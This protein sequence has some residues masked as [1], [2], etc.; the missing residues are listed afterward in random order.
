[1]ASNTFVLNLLVFFCNYSI[2]ISQKGSNFSIM[3]ILPNLL[4]NDKVMIWKMW[5][6]ASL[7][8]IRLFTLGTTIAQT[9]VMHYCD[10]E[11][12]STDRLF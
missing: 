12:P 5:S 4:H 1:M 10:A 7:H 11:P 9:E 2:H 8:T 3:L 6:C